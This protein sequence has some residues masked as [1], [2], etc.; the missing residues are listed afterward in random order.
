MNILRVY[1]QELSILQMT[2]DDLATLLK[3]LFL[4]TFSPVI[5]GNELFHMPPNPLRFLFQQQTYRYF[6][7]F[8]TP[9]RV[10]MRRDAESD[11]IRPYRLSMQRNSL[12]QPVKARTYSA[13][14]NVKPMFHQS[15]VLIQQRNHICD[16]PCRHQ[17]HARLI[18]ALGKS[19]RL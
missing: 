1:N 15:P 9:C 2:V 5:I 12:D 19:A 3:S 13:G 17:I 11:L 14:N 18:A 16:R 8:N 4:Q 7:I 10:K 6:R